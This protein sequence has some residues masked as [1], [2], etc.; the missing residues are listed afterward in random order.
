MDD[1]TKDAKL[2]EEQEVMDADA[3]TG[4]VEDDVRSGDDAIDERLTRIENN[5]NRLLG[6]VS[7]IQKAQGSLVEMG[8]VIREDPT[9]ETTVDDSFVPLDSLD[10]TI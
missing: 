7:A 3:D 1:E 4:D 2:D 6:T 5:V 10:F 8:A 9:E